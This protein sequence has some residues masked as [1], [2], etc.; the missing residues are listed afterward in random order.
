MESN[1]L[2]TPRK[3]LQ[4]AEELGYLKPVEKTKCLQELYQVALQDLQ[5]TQHND[6]LNNIE[7]QLGN[8]TKAVNLKIPLM[9]IIGD[10]QGGDGI[11]GRH[12]FYGLDAQ[13]ISRICDASPAQ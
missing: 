5:Q 7:L 11:C 12:L 1:C 13:W 6:S 2:H 9:F 10:N 4:S 8:K 3:N